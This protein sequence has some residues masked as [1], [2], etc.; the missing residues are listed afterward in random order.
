MRF[1][2]D[3]GALFD[4]SAR[5]YDRF[6]PCYPDP[7]INEVASLSRIGPGSRLLE[8]GCGTGQ[9]TL[10][11]ARRGFFIDCVDPGKNM[12]AVAR[13]KC[14]QWPRV[15]FLAEKFEAAPLEPRAYDLVFSAHAFHWVAPAVRLKKAARLLRGK[16]SLA[17]LYNYPAPADDEV[18]ERLSSLIQRESGGLLS[19]WQYSREVQSWAREI[20]ASGLF[21]DLSVCRHSWRQGYTADAYVGLFRTYSDFL[22]LPATLQERVARCIHRFI[23]RHGGSICR[24][25]HSLLIH[26][27]KSAAGPPAGTRP[28]SN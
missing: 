1:A 2:I 3:H 23:T 21:E 6:R 22:S 20:S 4:A 11:L 15:T 25:Y 27:R 7:V 17:L 10:A 14:A 19:A 9:A 16:G 8:V 26:A 18:M 13:K 28:R 12:M 5:A 24:P